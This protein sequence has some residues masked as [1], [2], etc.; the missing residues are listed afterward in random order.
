MVNAILKRFHDDV[1]SLRRY[2][3]EEQIM[4]YERGRYWLVRPHDQ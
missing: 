1:S 3:I 4:M 2:L